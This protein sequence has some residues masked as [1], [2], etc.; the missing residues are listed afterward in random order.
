[1]SGSH[2]GISSARY[3]LAA[4][5]LLSVFND[6]GVG[7]DAAG[8]AALPFLQTHGLA[9]CTVA[10]D[11][12]RIGEA[13]ST[14]DDGVISHVNLL[15]QALG[16]GRPALPGSRG[17]VARASVTPCGGL[18]GWLEATFFN[19]NGSFPASK[20]HGLLRFA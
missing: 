17:S 2:G 20:G 14:L 13:E 6:A 19:E 7:K 4:R 15:A 9:A 18:L 10:H 11:S 5:P 1:M 12:A 8:L 3:A 16:A